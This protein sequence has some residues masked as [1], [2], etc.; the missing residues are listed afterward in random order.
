[1]GTITPLVKVA[2]SYWI[3][4]AAAYTIT[5]CIS[6]T[7]VGVLLGSFPV[8]STVRAY[9]LGI[10]VLFSF[11]AFVR[12]WAGLK[13]PLLECR[14]QTEKMWADEYGFIVASAMWGFHIGL[15]FVTYLSNG[16]F[17][18][19]AAIVLTW[20]RPLDG[21][22]LMLSYWLG[23]ALPVWLLPA[24]WPSRDPELLI[25]NLLASRT[26]FGK[27]AGL[28]CVCLALAIVLDKFGK[29]LLFK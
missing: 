6:A 26:M 3:K 16:S 19:L 14:R 24:L 8:V 2:H 22:L 11:L 18:V 9:G 7:C 15:G 12:E 5:G 10:V 17:I 1:M 27:I 28:T 29:R 20:G 13:V 21:A 25:R 23:R 4:A